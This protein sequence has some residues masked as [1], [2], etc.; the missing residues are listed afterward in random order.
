M[1]E[2]L[3]LDF[4]EIIYRTNVKELVEYAD[5]KSGSLKLSLNGSSCRGEDEADYW[6]YDGRLFQESDIDTKEID[7][8][9]IPIVFFNP[10]FRRKK[11]IPYSVIF[12]K[13][14]KIQEVG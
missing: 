11:I 6:C 8:K 1:V 7:K 12:E 2:Q 3:D 14:R 5:F 13:W 9:L 4:K 10:L